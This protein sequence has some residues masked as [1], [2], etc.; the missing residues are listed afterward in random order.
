MI[1][2]PATSSTDSS[3]GSELTAAAPGAP[4]QTSFD[5]VLALETL[6]AAPMA[7]LAGPEDLE[8]GHRRTRGR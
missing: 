2:A 6:G 4:A 1:A 8:G 7:G 3:V 5:L